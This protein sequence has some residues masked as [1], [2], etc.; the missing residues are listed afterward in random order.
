[1]QINLCL[2]KIKISINSAKQY[3]GFFIYLFRR[4]VCFHLLCTTHSLGESETERA[5]GP[6]ADSNDEDKS[7]LPALMG[8]HLIE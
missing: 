7:V 2:N 3:T 6:P 8:P 1:M 5:A 4:N